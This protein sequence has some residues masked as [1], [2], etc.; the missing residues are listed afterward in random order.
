MHLA[1][2]WTAS[3][4]IDTD[5]PF[6]ATGSVEVVWL[7]GER[8]GTRAMVSE[9]ARASAVVGAMLEILAVPEDAPALNAAAFGCIAEFAAAVPGAHLRG[10]GTKVNWDELAAGA[11]GLGLRRALL[12]ATAPHLSVRSLASRDSFQEPVATPSRARIG[13]SSDAPDRQRRRTPK[14]AG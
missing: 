13:V 9:P 8:D 12:R 7:T 3:A 11:Q 4:L 2:R 6:G 10:D 14:P 5:R 1:Q